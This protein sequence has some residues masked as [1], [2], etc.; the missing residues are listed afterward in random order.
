[1]TSPPVNP[2]PP[3]AAGM[4]RIRFF[5]GQ[6]FTLIELTVVMLIIALLAAVT[7]PSLGRTWSNHNLHLAA[8]QLQQEIR[9]MGQASLIKEE[10]S[11][12]I[13]F[14]IFGNYYI[15]YGP[16]GTK[17]ISL[18]AW[19]ELVNTN[20]ENDI[21]YF[22]AR[23]MPAKGGHISLRNSLTRDY[24]YVIVAAITGRTRISDTPPGNND[25]K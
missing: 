16:E 4:F 6:G 12:K 21:M 7:I 18:P 25:D 23:G 3:K 8:L 20:Y 22:S 17:K 24:K 5:P 11:Y 13:S 15:I 9:T 14:S 2:A 1:M 10:S 19:V